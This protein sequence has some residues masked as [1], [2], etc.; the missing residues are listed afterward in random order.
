[1]KIR[2]LPSLLSADFARLADEIARV[3]D[4][5]ADML[6]VDVM[7][8]HFVPNITIGPLVVEA[9]KRVARL[10]LDVHLMIS[11]PDGYADSFIDAGADRLT[12]HIEAHPA[13]RELAGR[14]RSK[15][16]LPGLCIS[17]ETGV[18]AIEPYLGI[19][20]HAL[21]MTVRPGFGGQELIADCIEKVRLLREK[22]PELNIEVDGGIYANTIAPVAFAGANEFVAG[23]AIFKADDPATVIS[24]MREI[25]RSA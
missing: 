24:S 14:I 22:A 4:A 21:V 8:G 5:G 7:D 25:A 10:P 18:E 12:F 16:V 19:I 9:I 2:I 3:E 17:P 20:N 6:H 23:T 11:D 13:A 15:G 1:M